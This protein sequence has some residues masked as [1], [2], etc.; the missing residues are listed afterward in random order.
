MK[1]IALLLLLGIEPIRIEH[2]LI[3][4]NSSQ[5][6]S[7]DNPCQSQ[8]IPKEIKFLIQKEEPVACYEI[9]YLG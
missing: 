8:E 9:N 4:P 5:E 7:C 6:C 2:H 1:E 3:N